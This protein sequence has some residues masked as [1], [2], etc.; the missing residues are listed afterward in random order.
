MVRAISAPRRVLLPIIGMAAF[1]LMA[2]QDASETDGTQD[3]P[4]AT[5]TDPPA[6]EAMQE[7]ATAVRIEVEDD[8]VDYTYAWSAE[9]AAIPA[10]DTSFREQSDTALAELRRM[11]EDEAKFRSEN[12]MEFGGLFGSTEWETAGQSER[13]LS[14]AGETAAYTGGAHP[15]SGAIALLWD[16]EANDEITIRTL[17]GSD[18]SRDGALRDGFCEKLKAEQ[19]DRRGV[20]LEGS[21]GQCPG[22]EQIII[23]PKDGDG[24]GLFERIL[25]TA[26]PYVAG[27]YAEGSYEIELPVDAAIR[28]AIA[29]PFRAS[30]AAD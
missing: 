21:F 18:R 2:C 22:L 6:P 14:L 24:D 7:Q 26:S 9:A 1:G 16:R 10:I 30:F 19:M 3:P 15:N 12:G 17:F 28:N 5:M 23:A 27:P 29:E 11:A 13:L 8:L 25:M 20:E 4:S